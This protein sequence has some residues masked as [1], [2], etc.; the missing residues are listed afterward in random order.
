MKDEIHAAAKGA[1]VGGILD[2]E[3][4][5][6]EIIEAFGSTKQHRGE[7]S[8]DLPISS[9]VALRPSDFFRQGATWRSAAQGLHCEGWDRC[10]DSIVRYFTSNLEDSLFPAPY[11]YQELRIGFTGGAVY[12]KLG[13]HRT[14]AAK[15]WLASHYGEEAIFKQANCYYR[16]VKYSLKRLMEECIDEGSTLKFFYY[17]TDRFGFKNKLLRKAGIQYLVLVEHASSSCDL[18]ILDSDSENLVPVSPGRNA[19]SRLLKIDFRSKCLRLDFKVVPVTLMKMML[20]ENPIWQ[21]S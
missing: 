5:D 1:L 7:R 12:C 10:R 20:D 15:A 9:I 11:S 16:P 19:V 14:A 8:L 13:N 21:D 18:Y 3:I 17:T 2:D 6:S 4:Y